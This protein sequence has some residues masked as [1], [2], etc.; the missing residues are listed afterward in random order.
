MCSWVYQI[1]EVDGR[2]V[3]RSAPVKNRHGGA[4]LAGRREPTRECMSEA[5]LGFLRPAAPAAALRSGARA[6]PAVRRLGRVALVSRVS[7]AGELAP[8]KAG[9]ARRSVSAGRGETRRRKALRLWEAAA[10]VGRMLKGAFGRR[11]NSSL[12][13]HGRNGPWQLGGV[14]AADFGRQV[15]GD[16]TGSVSGW[17]RRARERL[18]RPARASTEP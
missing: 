12:A 17:L 1:A 5:G 2:H 15:P 9:N 16:A 11:G 14:G 3:A 6:K 18:N 8:V 13:A 10:L 4:G 7:A